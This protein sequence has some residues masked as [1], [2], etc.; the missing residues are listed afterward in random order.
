MQNILIDPVV[1]VF[2]ILLLPIGLILALVLID[3]VRQRGRFGINV[4]V[5]KCPKCG[6]QVP[7]IRKPKSIRQFLWGGWTCTKCG[8]EIDKWGNEIL[9][10]KLRSQ[11]HI[12]AT[13]VDSDEIRPV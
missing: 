10:K 13:D 5:P 9:P 1:W 6:Q 8:C 2:L 12:E 11:C 7:A 3:T 4:H